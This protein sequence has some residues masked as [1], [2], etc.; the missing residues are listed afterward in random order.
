MAGSTCGKST[1]M[2]SERPEK[3][4]EES[5]A[6]VLEEIQD[7]ADNSFGFPHIMDS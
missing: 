1:M 2:M 3:K 4:K 6:S 5:K 7:R